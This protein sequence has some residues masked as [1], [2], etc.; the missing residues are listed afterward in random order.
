MY[1]A[2]KENTMS[3]KS[4]GQ[5][6]HGSQKN[7]VHH[8]INN[9]SLSN[10]QNGTKFTFTVSGLA[11]PTA[12]F[13]VSILSTEPRCHCV[14]FAQ[15]LQEKCSTCFVLSFWH[16]DC[17][18]AKHFPSKALKTLC[19]SFHQNYRTSLLKAKHKM[20]NINYR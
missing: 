2:R 7:V 11:R 15:N 1:Q 8:V 17:C 12:P 3:K 19:Y 20:K 18:N 9:F 6:A 16:I 14:R 10:E 13:Y 5:R 4:I